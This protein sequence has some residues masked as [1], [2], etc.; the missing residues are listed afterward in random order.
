M[1]RYAR[2]PQIA[3]RRMD[4]DSFL[5]NPDNDALYQLN[6]TGTAI[7]HLLAEPMAV[8]EI[9][10]SFIEAFPDVGQK[11]LRADIEKAIDQLSGRGLIIRHG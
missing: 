11:A 6:G 2:N 1:I 5:V 10:A 9:A 4:D 8:E 3:D 7:W